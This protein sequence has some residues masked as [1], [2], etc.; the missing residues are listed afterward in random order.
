MKNLL[1]LVA[2]ALPSGSLAEGPFVDLT[3]DEACKEAEARSKVVM[4]DFY[5]TWCGPCK[6]LDATTWKDTGVIHW[7]NKNTVPLKLDAEVHTEL[8]KRFKVNAYPT[9]VF[10]EPDGS[11]KGSIVG[12]KGPEA[13]LESSADVMAGVKASDKLREQVAAKPNDP[14]L[15]M[16]LAK[17]LK[18]EEEYEEALELLLWCWDHGSDDLFNGF[19]GVRVSFLM[20]DFEALAKVYEPTTTELELRL[21]TLRLT[22]LKPRLS[23]GVARDVVAQDILA[24]NRA[25]ET[26]GRNVEIYDALKAAA[27]EGK[28]TNGENAIRVLAL[29]CLEQLLAAQRYED[30]VV[31]IGDSRAWFEK[32]KTGILR[33][34]SFMEDDESMRSTF[35]EGLIK[36]AVQVYEALV[37]TGKHDPDASFISTELLEF[38]P[39]ADVWNSLIASAGKAGRK[40]IQ[41]QLH[42]DA[43][44]SLPEGERADLTR[45]GE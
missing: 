21:G 25:L 23:R 8:A 31:G 9:M 16:G 33:M 29:A 2:L 4:I 13:F 38:E 14:V 44:A 17:E 3:F 1:L 10:V 35:R 18:R 11:L 19:V 42:K 6:K 40:D 43:L 37:G 15:K 5:T 36:E 22:L 7:L 30:V 45:L 12:Y 27:A 28:V 32:K 39:A 41:A 20:S 34:L 24:L 26:P